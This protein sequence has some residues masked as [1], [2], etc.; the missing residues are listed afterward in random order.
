MSPERA[1]IATPLADGA[2]W[3]RVAD[4]SWD[5]PLD[6][7]WAGRVGGRWNA[8]GAGPTLYLNEDVRTARAQLPRLLVGTAIDVEDLRD[9]APYVLVEVTL[10][11]RQR[12]ADAVSDTGLASLGLPRTYPRRRDGRYVPWRPCQTAGRAVRE[13]GLRGVHA[14]SAATPDGSGREL[15]WFPARGATAHSRGAA[16]PFAAWRHADPSEA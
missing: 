8:P 3:W 2:S 13:A 7:T 15:A 5:D 11:G 12:V 1:P 9:D 6:P 14:R 16:L 4:A 10:P